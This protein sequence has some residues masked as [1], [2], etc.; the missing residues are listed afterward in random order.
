MSTT[1]SKRIGEGV[2]RGELYAALAY[3]ASDKFGGYQIK[4][5]MTNSTYKHYFCDTATYIYSSASGTLNIVGTTVAITGNLTISGSLTYG[6]T[7]VP[8]ATAY[9]GTVT[10][11]IDDTGYDVKFYG[12]TS[13]KYLLWDESADGVVLVGTFVETGNMAVTGTFT[14]TGAPT[15]TGAVTITGD[16]GITG[17]TTFTGAVNVGVDATGHDVTFFGETTAYKFLWDQNQNT[18]GGVTLVGTYIQT[19]AMTITGAV[20]VTGNLAFTGDLTLTGA[21]SQTGNTAIV[22]TLTVGIDA[23]G[24]DVIFY[25][26]TTGYSFTWDQNQNTNGGVTIVGTLI[27]TGAVTITGAVGITGNVTMA[28]TSKLYFLDTG[29]YIW[30][31]ANGV[32]DIVSDTT[33][34]LTAAALTVTGATSHVGALTMATTSKLFFLDSGLYIWSSANG[35]LDIVSD[36]TLTLTAPTITITGSTVITLAG[37]TLITVGGPANFTGIATHGVTG[38]RLTHT[39][40]TP[41]LQVYTTNNSTGGADAVP[42]LIDSL[43]TGAGGVGQALKVQNKV[44]TVALGAYCNA[45]YGILDLGTTGSVVGLGAPICSEITF[46]TGTA[47]GA[48][49]LAGVEIELTTGAATVF[50]AGTVVSCLYISANGATKGVIDDNAYLVDMAGFTAGA[51]HIWQTGGTLPSTV[52]GSLRIRVGG[53]AYYIPVYTSVVTA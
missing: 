43:M 50:V 44:A 27:Q 49:T 29:L 11:G 20:T 34:T 37:A 32:L 15:I 16:V 8:V 51:A 25:G 31:S 7:A 22:G 45:I 12:A 28:S 48:G 33:L 18:N 1:I 36:A 46:N 3:D 5:V 52:G 24:W 39:A 2:G 47:G 42:V 38:T 26:E 30:S 4:D 6:A 41:N 10:V 14:L 35:V 21:I 23:T 53:I 19:G 17:T 13:G 40:G 9:L